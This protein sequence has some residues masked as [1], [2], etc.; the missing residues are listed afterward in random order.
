MNRKRKIFIFSLLL[1]GQIVMQRYMRQLNFHLDL[2]YLV[3][4]YISVT[5]GFIKSLA[6]A[7]AIGLATD[8]LS[9]NVLGVFGFS[10]TIAAYL[11]NELSIRIDLKNN[12]FVFLLIAISMA[13]SNS[14]ANL[15]YHFIL[16]YP[17][18][19]SLVLYQPLITAAVGVAIVA[20]AK[21]RLYLDVY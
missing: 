5:S 21:I 11:L 7:S 1:L 4:V 19:L 9:G 15:F 2:L 10:R 13:V 18:K 3:L 20:V 8:Y 16:G 6:A 12:V 14:I 17:L